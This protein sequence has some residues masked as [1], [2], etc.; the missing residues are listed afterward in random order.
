L[1][2]VLII[3]FVVAEISFNPVNT[4]GFKKQKYCAALYRKKPPA[5][6]GVLRGKG[7]EGLSRGW[8]RRCCTGFAE[9]PV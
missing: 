5:E 4:V 7:S 3:S 6:K 9:P 2:E 8:C 1:A